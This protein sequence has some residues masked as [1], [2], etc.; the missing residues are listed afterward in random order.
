MKIYAASSWRNELYDDIVE[1][2]LA[3]TNHAVYNF[4]AKNS[5]FRWVKELS[6]ELLTGHL[7]TA[8]YMLALT[9]DE[10][11]RV[12]AN[13]FNALI[14]SDICLLVLPSGRSAHLEAGLMLGM[15][16]KLIIY[17]PIMEEPELMYK[18]GNFIVTEKSNLIL[19]L[20][21]FEK[22]Y[23]IAGNDIGE[24]MVVEGWEWQMT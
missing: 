15:G 14:S 2:I 13:D 18:M 3:E 17:M 9:T 4:K 7:T 21:S 22:K 8:D 20:K 24:G 6:R 5:A 10:A 1:T 12:Y 11:N 19:L 23:V 16:K